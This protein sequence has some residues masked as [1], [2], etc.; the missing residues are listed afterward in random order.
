MGSSWARIHT[1]NG[2]K[3]EFAPDWYQADDQVIK[4]LVKQTAA[5]Y[6]AEKKLTPR[7]P[8]DCQS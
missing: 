5:K 4:P 3:W 6:A 8:A 2:Q 7:T 1:W